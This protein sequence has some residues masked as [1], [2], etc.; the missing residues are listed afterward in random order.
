MIFYLAMM[1]KKA[2]YDVWIGSNEQSASYNNVKLSSLVT[3]KKPVWRFISTA[4]WD[5][6]NQIDVI[7]HD[8]GRVKYAFEVENTT[9]ITSAIAR[10]SNITAINVNRLIIIPKERERL[11]YRKIE[12]PLIKENI[13][14]FKW[15]FIFYDDLEKFFNQYGKKEKISTDSFDKMFR[16]PKSNTEQKQNSLNIYL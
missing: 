15:G 1:G 3:I 6:I 5:R 2:K 7:W 14:R 11:L 16:M 13:E 12:E 4:Y 10:S 9:T 8:S